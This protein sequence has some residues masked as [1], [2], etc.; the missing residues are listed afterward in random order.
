MRE[1]TRRGGCKILVLHISF[2]LC[3]R[4]PVT[5]HP[6]V[7]PTPARCVLLDKGSAVFDERFLIVSDRFWKRGEKEKDEKKK[8]TRANERCSS[9]LDG[10]RQTPTVFRSLECPCTSR[11][12]YKCRKLR[13]LCDRSIACRIVL[14]PLFDR[15]WTLETQIEN[16]DLEIFFQHF[17]LTFSKW[18]LLPSRRN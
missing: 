12:E 10:C 7:W 1:M 13:I 8:G 15:S 9:C 18:Y 4:R 3:N 11:R 17:T 2:R 6:F 14:R 5:P 16:F